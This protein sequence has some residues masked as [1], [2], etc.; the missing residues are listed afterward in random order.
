MRAYKISTLRPT[1]SAWPCSSNA[2]L[3]LRR[4]IAHQSRLLPELL[5]PLLRLMEFTIPFPAGSAA[6][7]DYDHLELSTMMGTREISGRRR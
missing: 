6:G 4:H 1:V 3:R 2:S 5:F 7:F